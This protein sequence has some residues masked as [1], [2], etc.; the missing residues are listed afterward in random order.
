MLNTSPKQP[1]PE[2]PTSNIIIYGIHEGRLRSLGHRDFRNIVDCLRLCQDQKASLPFALNFR[3]RIVA[4]VRINRNGDMAALNVPRFEQVHLPQDHPIFQEELG[5]PHGV[6]QVIDGIGTFKTMQLGPSI[7]N[8]PPKYSKNPDAYLM[9]GSLDPG[10]K[11]G[12]T[13]DPKYAPV[14]GTILVVRA[15]R[16]DI[17]F[18]RMMILVGC[19]WRKKGPDGGSQAGFEGCTGRLRLKDRRQIVEQLVNELL[20]MWEASCK[21]EESGYVDPDTS[22]GDSSEQVEGVDNDTDME[23]SGDVDTFFDADEERTFH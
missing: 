21:A 4:G 16:R 15:D 2:L 6:A 11:H 13:I 5:D 18:D 8:E 19:T 23:E 17:D 9:L 1:V 10:S 20:D 7:S 22:M 12:G 14:C 3:S